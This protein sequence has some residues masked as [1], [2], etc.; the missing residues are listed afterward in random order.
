MD[1]QGPDVPV[2]RPLPVSRRD[3]GRQHSIRREE[4][5]DNIELSP[6]DVV[7]EGRSRPHASALDAAT[8]VVRRNAFV[9]GPPRT[10]GARIGGGPAYYRG[11]S[12][13]AFERELAVFQDE[14]ERRY[15]AITDDEDEEESDEKS[16][17]W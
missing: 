11:L 8:R 14:M 9:G 12:N 1:A 5:L 13:R 15:G 16:E 10:G 6:R 2:M 4:G 3:E 17:E 7:A